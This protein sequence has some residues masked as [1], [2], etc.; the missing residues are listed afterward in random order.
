[1]AAHDYDLI[2]M[3]DIAR[4][5]GQSR[6]TVGNWKGRNPDD[7]PAERGRGP[8]GPLYDRIEVTEWLTA[9]G[10]L[11]QR[12]PEVVA[13]WALAD[14]LRGPMT[15]EDAMQL[16]LVLLAVMATSPNEWQS[17][18]R[19]R[20]DRLDT[21]L[22]SAVQSLFPYAV[23]LLPRGALP[24]TS[25]ARAVETLSTTDAS[26]V[27]AMTDALIEQAA[28]S[29]GYRGGEYLT[30]ETV[31]RL[32]VALAAPSGIVY[33]PASGIGQLMAD[34]AM[35]S[36]TITSITG[37]EINQRVW[38]MAQLN[39]AIHG[40]SGDVA[41]G[42]VFAADAYS[43]LRADCVVAVPPWNQKLAV[44]E[45]LHDDPRWVFGEPGSNDGNTAW[46]QHCLYHLA[47]GGRAVLVL[48]NGALFESGRS[49][50][51][52][53]RIVKA[54]LLDAVI[55]L[56]AGLFPT[57]GI[58][59]SILIFVKGRPTEHGR[60]APTL[61]VDV[62]EAS[63]DHSARARVLPEFLV[64]SVA[65][66]YRDW[67]NGRYPS[68][69]NA[70]VASFEELALN[71]FVIAPSRYLAL[72]QPSITLNEAVR[73]RSELANNFSRLVQASK[74]ADDELAQIL[75]VRR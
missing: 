65:R 54:G 48:P 26:T 52:R 1:M 12:P 39:L 4:L 45:K 30:P 71:D 6:A 20:A 17:I 15:I 41:L 43:D 62:S 19:S 42:D 32:M 18:R 29:L 13:V 73:R 70:A 7:F 57:T 49:G 31:R 58:P 61:M 23:D 10:R 34:V 8:R 24:H 51:M 27:A 68:T 64:E 9:T 25:V 46:I 44:L 75:E 21:T 74:D 28:H 47:D 72:S 14:E 5:A 3:A 35:T 40:V 60:P 55:S 50:R 2:S 59:C 56:P 36:P 53:Q 33:N 69:E 11:D 22:R 16:S 38:A 66:Q 67:R 63:D 37:Q